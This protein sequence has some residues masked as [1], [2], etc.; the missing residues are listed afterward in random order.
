MATELEIETPGERRKPAR[1][2]GRKVPGLLIRGVGEQIGTRSVK[3][4]GLPH[5]H[6]AQ[7]QG[8]AVVVTRTPAAGALPVVRP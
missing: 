4:W 5:P 1:E 6:P 8:R 7:L 3:S 2:K